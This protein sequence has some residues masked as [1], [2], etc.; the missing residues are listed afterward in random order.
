MR[1][2]DKP[3]DPN[4][5]SSS[6]DQGEGLI[7]FIKGLFADGGQAPEGEGGDGVEAGPPGEGLVFGAEPQDEGERLRRSVGMPP[8]YHRGNLP[9]DVT[10]GRGNVGGRTSVAHGEGEFGT[11]GGPVHGRGSVDVL[12][13]SGQASGSVGMNAR[14]GEL[15]AQGQASARA[16]VMHAEG[17]AH[18]NLGGL[19]EAHARGSVTVLGASAEA[20]GRAGVNRN[21]Q[22]YAQGHVQAEAVLVKAEGESHVSLGGGLVESYTRGE[23]YVGGRA[24]ADVDAV[25]DPSKGTARAAAKGEAFVGAYA[26]VQQQMDVGGVGATGGARAYAGAGVKF[27]A[28]AGIENGKLDF[29][30]DVGAAVGIGAGFK[31]DVSIDIP[32]V[33]ATVDKYVPGAREVFALT[34]GLGSMLGGGGVLGGLLGGGKGG[35]VLGGL[36]GGGGGGGLLGGL[37]GGGGGQEGGAPGE[38]AGFVPGSTFNPIHDPNPLAPDAADQNKRKERHPSLEETRARDKLNFQWSGG[39]DERREL[40]RIK[41]K[42]SKDIG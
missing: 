27:E 38:G 42:G 17:A 5:G 7:E 36:L 10:L 28:H 39:H 33:A 21:G 35:G 30:F 29:G 23:A 3:S 24:R 31:V 1:L 19:G 32:K 15:Y 34:S 41:G 6:P 12:G 4:V 25:F 20:Q 37:L 26:E 8:A 9:G 16:H 14:R 40:D 13:A 22:I 18:S 2:T 11:P